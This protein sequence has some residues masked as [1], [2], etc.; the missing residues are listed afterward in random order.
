MNPQY[1]DDLGEASTNPAEIQYTKDKLPACLE[2][3]DLILNKSKTEEFR[4]SKNHNNWKKCKFLGSYI[5]TETD[6]NNRKR[7]LLNAADQLKYIFHSKRLPMRVKIK[8]FNVYLESIFLYNS[9]LWTTTNTLNNKIDAFHRR[10][11]RALVL[12]IRYPKIIK[13]TEVYEKTKQ[14]PWLTKIKIRRMRWIGHAYRLNKNTPAGKSIRYATNQF[15]RNQGR[16]KETWIN[17][18]NKQLKEQNINLKNIYDQAKN[19]KNWKKL[20]KQIT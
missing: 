16:P 2:K 7:L 17:L 18:I 6:I 4:V 13:N 15:I 8:A 11:L 10:M 19:K 1:A 14:Q 9:E 20:C 3:R 12:N 5:D